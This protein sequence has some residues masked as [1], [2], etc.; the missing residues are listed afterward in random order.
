M[1]H[2]NLHQ[3]SK[4]P[5][6]A[7]PVDRNVLLL[8]IPKYFNLIKRNF[9]LKNKIF[10][11]NLI[12]SYKKFPILILSLRFELKDLNYNLNIPNP[13]KLKLNFHQLFSC[14][15]NFHW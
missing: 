9:Y 8:N 13:K 10:K 3:L 2:L 6:L 14:Y 7:D 5:Q 4:R 15:V 1:F 11:H 12:N